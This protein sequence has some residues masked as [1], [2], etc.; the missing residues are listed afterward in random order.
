MEKRWQIWAPTV[1][2]FVLVLGIYIGMKLGY[3]Q[4]AYV[5][6]A[7]DRQHQKIN[8]LINYIN[9]DYVDNIDTDSLLDKTIEDILGQLDPHSTYIHRSELTAVEE[10]MQGNFQGIGVEFEL[11]RDTIVV[12]SPISGGPSEQ[13]GI[14]AGDRIVTVNGDTVA[15]V[16]LRNRDVMARLR[17][18]KGSRVVVQIYRNDS[19]DLLDFTIERDEIPL[20]SIDV[21]YMIDDQTGYIKLSRFVETSYSEFLAAKKQLLAQGMTQLV[22]D[23]RGNPGGYLHIADQIADE[24]LKEGK[25]IVFTE[26]RSRERKYYYAGKQGELEDMPLVVLIDEGSA[27]ASEII[28]GALQDN[29][30][31]EI[32]GRRSFG[33]GLVQEQWELSDGSALRLTVARYYTP[34]GR[35][36]QRPYTNDHRAYYMESYHGFNKALELH[37][38]PAE[39]EE[40]LTFTTPGGDTVY[41]G[42][43]IMP[44]V[45]VPVDT[46]GRTRWFYEVLSYGDLRKF[47]FEYTDQYRNEF[48]E[49]YSDAMEFAREFELPEDVYQLYL[50]QARENGALTEWG[51]N[52]RS[53]L[54]VRTQIKAYDRTSDL[55]NR[56]LLP[57][58]PPE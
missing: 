27:S 43:G 44:D 17:G 55:G 36:I 35:C 34:T 23:L 51:H 6:M 5:L 9:R 42:G 10:S 28:A 31:A 46:A 38:P 20:V 14:E 54:L 52:D 24:F 57:S 18:K 15:G 22:L 49:R 29:D 58:D 19:T 7:P 11:Q 13:L 25:L 2:A 50:Q 37:S 56:G 30:R 26:G 8:Q 47:S 16:G 32:I 4:H 45:F 3:G 33:K 1:L 53:E 40:K 12:I 48:R 41:G 39:A 21:A